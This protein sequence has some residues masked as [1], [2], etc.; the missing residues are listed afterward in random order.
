[1]TPEVKRQLNFLA[2]MP[3]GHTTMLRKD[4]QELLIETG[5]Q[6]LAF[7]GLYDII[8]T[9]IGA[10]VYRVSLKRWGMK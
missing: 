2:S 6:M 8:A 3:G 7:G 9:D 5:G 4:A 10:G 1:M